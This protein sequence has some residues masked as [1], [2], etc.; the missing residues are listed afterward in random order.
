[1]VFICVLF[2][3]YIVEMLAAYIFFSRAG[4]K[5]FKTIYCV[6]ISFALFTSAFFVNLLGDNTVWFNALYENF[7]SFSFFVA[8][9]FL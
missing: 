1:M 6:L 2:I 3:V 8:F 9:Y 4:E 5:R 7:K